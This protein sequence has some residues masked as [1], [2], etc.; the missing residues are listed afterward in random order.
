ML[1]RS[2]FQPYAGCATR[3]YAKIPLTSGVHRLQS[4]SGFQAYAFGIGF[5][6]SYAASVNDISA[7]HVDNDSIVCGGTTVTLNSPVPLTNAQWT[8]ASAPATF[9]T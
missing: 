1:F 7:P 5:G 9:A 8:A 3:S 6:E 4:V 2:L